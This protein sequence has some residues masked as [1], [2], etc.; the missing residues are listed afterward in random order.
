MGKLAG[1]KLLLLG[2]GTYI[3]AINSFVKSNNIKTISVSYDSNATIHKYSDKQYVTD[4]TNLEELKKIIEYEKID[5]IYMGG[6]ETVITKT[7]QF[8]NNLGFPCYCNSEQWLLFQNKAK[9]KELL[10]KF[11]LPTVQRF[12]YTPNN[13]CDIVF[14]VITKPADGCGSCGFSVCNNYEELDKGYKYASDNSN[15]GEVIVENFVNNE[16]HVVFYSFSNGKPVFLLLQDKYPFKYVDHG[17]Y[18]AGMHIYKSDCT[19][20]FYN[21][22]H[23]KLI[24]MFNFAGIKEGTIWIE[25][26]HCNN[27]YYFNEA[28]YRYGGSLSM[29]PIDYFT[30]VN[31]VAADIHYALTGESKLYGFNH[32]VNCSKIKK[33]YCVYSIYLKPGKIGKIEGLEKLRNSNIIGVFKL[34]RDDAEIPNTGDFSQ[35]FGFIHFVCDNRAEFDEIIKLINDTVSIHDI[36]GNDMLIKHNDIFFSKVRID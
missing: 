32:I 27:N 8:I 6:H 35:N 33:Y 9:F 10:N 2:G 21:L 11:E 13:K 4:S 22:F 16:G 30:G 31:Q 18:V 17:S 15:T 5:G 12:D 7:C 1:K 34:K 26:F 20:E 29:F 19:E 14:P 36:N 28:G 3:E 24:K 23:N 25:V